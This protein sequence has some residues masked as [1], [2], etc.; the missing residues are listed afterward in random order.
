MTRGE[1]YWCDLNRGAIGSEQRGK[2]PV[3]GGILSAHT[4]CVVAGVSRKQAEIRAS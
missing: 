2:R 4:V 1:I 3:C